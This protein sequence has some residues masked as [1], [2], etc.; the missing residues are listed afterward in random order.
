[1]EIASLFNKSLGMVDCLTDTSK[2]HINGILDA[3]SMASLFRTV[4][5]LN[6]GERITLLKNGYVSA[7]N[8]RDALL[9]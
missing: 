8:I 1:M 3:N 9:M 4:S 5:T 7:F 2:C 6:D